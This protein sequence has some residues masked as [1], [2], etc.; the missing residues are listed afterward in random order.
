[1][2]SRSN[3]KIVIVDESSGPRG[4]HGSHY[5]IETSNVTRDEVLEQL[6]EFADYAKANKGVLFLLKNVGREAGYTLEVIAE[7]FDDVVFSKNVYVSA[8]V[9]YQIE[10]NE[11]GGTIDLAEK[12]QAAPEQLGLWD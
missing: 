6:R 9:M 8:Q 11:F 3:Q 10:D 1:M 4:A 12:I 7:L 2:T 5:F